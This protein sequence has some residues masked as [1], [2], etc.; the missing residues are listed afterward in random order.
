MTAF[1]CNG[2]NNDDDPE[3]CEAG[4]GGGRR[5]N[6]GEVGEGKYEGESGVLGMLGGVG[7][8]RVTASASVVEAAVVGRE[9]R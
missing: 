6:D 3:P 8:R 7:K 2:I 5:S 4:D 9:S 1:T